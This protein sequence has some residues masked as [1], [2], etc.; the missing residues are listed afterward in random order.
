MICK[1]CNNEI[2][3]GVAFCTWCGTPVEEKNQSAVYDG[4]QSLAVNGV[5]SKYAI[6]IIK[7]SLMLASL[8]VLFICSFFITYKVQWH[9]GAPTDVATTGKSSFF[10]LSQIFEKIGDR[11]VGYEASQKTLINSLSGLM[12]TAVL[13]TMVV[14]LVFLVLAVYKFVLGIVKGKKFSIT[15]FVVIPT[16]IYLASV[17]FVK[18]SLFS[19]VDYF[20]SMNFMGN[21]EVAFQPA[22]IV[23]MIITA[24]LLV[25]SLV[26]CVINEPKSISRILLKVVALAL[27]IALVF[28]VLL[29]ISKTT[30]FNA[31]LQSNAITVLFVFLRAYISNKGGWVNAEKELVLAVAI[32]VLA[33]AILALAVVLIIK[34]SKNIKKE[35]SISQIILSIVCTFLSIS[36]LVLYTICDS[37]EIGNLIYV[38]GKTVA[39]ICAVVFSL[40]VL[41]ISIVGFILKKRK[42]E[43]G[44]KI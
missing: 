25:S 32:F 15:K 27:I 36:Y 44:A 7:Q 24:T 2:E 21:I 14:N 1:N 10:F 22:I 3:E 4:Q 23:C 19:V 12:A 40:A 13:A 18:A 17:I 9:D 34:I 37:K 41:I 30:A 31:S 8:L 28:T 35:T 43:Q 42:I 16:A 6:E 5:R 38:S 33:I 26:L 11:V 29:P 20:I 39:P